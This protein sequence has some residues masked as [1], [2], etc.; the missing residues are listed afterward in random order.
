M[1]LWQVLLLIIAAIA[2]LLLV[3]GVGVSHTAIYLVILL[4][5]ALPFVAVALLIKWALRRRKSA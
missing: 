2:A 5:L 1:K 4:V 3:S